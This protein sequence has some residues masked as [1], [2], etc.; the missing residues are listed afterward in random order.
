MAL[1]ISAAGPRN[2]RPGILHPV[3]PGRGCGNCRSP[4]QERRL[5]NLLAARP[6]GHLAR[7]PHHL[8]GARDRLPVL[9]LITEGLW[10]R[11]G[12]PVYMALVRRWSK[13]FAILFAVGAVSGTILSFELD[14]SG[15]SSWATPAASSVPVF[16]GGV[17][18]LHR[19]HLSRTL[20]LRLGSP[21]AR[22]A[23]ADRVPDRHQRYGLG[24]LRHLRQ[25]LDEQPRRISHRRWPGGRRRPHCRHVQQRLV[26]AVAAHGPGR[27]HRHRSRR[28]RDS[29]PG[30]YCA[31]ATTP[32]TAP[33]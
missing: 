25:R 7:I 8:R 3:W 12:N 24:Y 28:G 6:D 26:P 32:T 13:G 30:G 16:G 31:A 18:L 27:L 20:S 33:A 2:D 29:T 5:T 10:L 23:L 19:G 1:S 15:R 17:R 9:L 4:G 21:L 11:T 22:G 14:S